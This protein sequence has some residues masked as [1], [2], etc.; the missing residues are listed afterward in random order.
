[1]PRAKRVQSVETYR[2][3]DHGSVTV[4]TTAVQLSSTSVHANSGIA[5]RADKDNAG[6]VFVGNSD[7]TT[8]TSDSTNGFPLYKKDVYIIPADDVSNVY[9]RATEADQIVYWMLI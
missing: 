2:H 6:T 7:V 4:G 1:M 9:V 3:L 8:G 5:I